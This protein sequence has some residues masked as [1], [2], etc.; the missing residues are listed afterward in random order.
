MRKPIPIPTPK[1][2]VRPDQDPED[3]DEL[4]LPAAENMIVRDG[5][6]VTRPGFEVFRNDINE[7]PLSYLE[8]YNGDA[9]SVVQA[10]DKSWRLLTSGGWQ[11]LAGASPLTGSATDI[12]VLKTFVRDGHAWVLGTNGANDP[13][14]WDGAGA[15]YADIGGS[16]PRARCMGVVFDRCVLGNLLTGPDA[17]PVNVTVSSNKNFDTGWGT[18]Q[19]IALGDTDGPLVSIVELGQFQAA[20]IKADTI[21]QLIAQGDTAPFRSVWTKSAI[22]GPPSPALTTKL[23]DGTCAFF[24]RDGLCSIYDGSSVAT[25]PYAVQ[26]AIADSMNPERLNRGWCSYDSTR[27]ELWVVYPLIGSN[28]PNGGVIINMDSKS[29]Y[30]IRFKTLRPTAGGKLRTA[31]GLRLGDVHVPLGTITQLIGDFAVNTG[32]RQ[33]VIGEMGGQSYLDT[34]LKDG[35]DTI[36]FSWDSA[37]RGLAELFVTVTRVRHR[38]KSTKMNQNVDFQIGQRNEADEIVYG[39]KHTINIGSKLR[40]ATGHRFSAEYMATRYSGEASE[41]ITF[42]GAAAYFVQRGQ[43]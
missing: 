8:F 2:G 3:V 4:E 9:I 34:G 38:F 25:L 18:E 35:A 24:G 19:V 15:S 7:R 11:T 26:K 14:K 30:P 28:E 29:V 39:Q 6:F 41:P 16:P 32:L 43:R 1:G 23:S 42:Q 12:P 37:V 13:K 21:Y 40:K 27:R 17:S 33:F 36:P 22:S 31:T 20:M 5:D 10:T